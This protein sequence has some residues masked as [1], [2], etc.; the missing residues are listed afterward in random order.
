MNSVC[1]LIFSLPFLF[2]FP[3]SNSLLQKMN[4]ETS[5]LSAHSTGSLTM[6]KRDESRSRKKRHKKEVNNSKN[7]TTSH[8]RSYS[9]KSRSEAK[10]K[11]SYLKNYDSDYLGPNRL[12]KNMGFLAKGKISNSISRL[13]E[14]IP[15]KLKARTNQDL[16]R[17]LE[18]NNGTNTHTKYSDLNHAMSQY[19]D[20]N[21]SSGEGSSYSQTDNVAFASPVKNSGKDRIERLSARKKSV[22]STESRHSA[23]HTPQHV[24]DE[25]SECREIIMKKLHPGITSANKSLFPNNSCNQANLINELFAIKTQYE[26]SRKIVSSSSNC[27]SS[28]DISNVEAMAASDFQLNPVLTQET[29]SPRQLENMFPLSQEYVSESEDEIYVDAQTLLRKSSRTNHRIPDEVYNKP[30]TAS[31]GRDSSVIIISSSSSS[32]ASPVWMPKT[33]PVKFV[34]EFPPTPKLYFRQKM[35]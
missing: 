14:L 23:K 5:S 11:S 21:V 28:Q 7:Q 25:F 35:F 19:R 2:N 30:G 20:K 24:K 6:Q 32:N 13:E 18:L 29:S 4:H 34:P 22:S 12:T 27:E 8:K 33:S 26:S 3:F 16:H 1:M 17:I 10:L 15:D 31:S 9:K